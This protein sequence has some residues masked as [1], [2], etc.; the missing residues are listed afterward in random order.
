[1]NSES[2]VITVDGK[3]ISLLQFFKDLLQSTPLID[4]KTRIT[5]VE[6]ISDFL[7]NS[8]ASPLPKSGDPSPNSPISSNV[9]MSSSKLVPLTRENCGMRSWFNLLHLTEITL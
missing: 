5:L 7:P 3:K 1:M 8:K 6:G 2:A 4:N 9:E